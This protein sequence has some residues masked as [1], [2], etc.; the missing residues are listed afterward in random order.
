MSE[1]VSHRQRWKVV[2][3]WATLAALLL[4]II[5]ERH[6]I[7]DT[8]NNLGNINAWA[9]L[10][11]I[12]I[13]A[14]NYHAQARLYQGL[15][16]V[17]GNKLSYKSL[18]RASL[19]L[20]FVNH[21]FPSGGVTGMS[22]FS[23]RLRKGQELIYLATP[24]GESDDHDS[25]RYNGEGI[26]VLDPA[27]N[28]SF[29]K[30]IPLQN[31]PA[32]MK[33]EEVS[34]MMISPATNYAYISTR[35]HLIALDLATDK[36]V[37]SKTYDPINTCCERG[38]VTPDGLTLDVGSNLQNYHRV[39][40]A[41]T[42]DLKGIIPTPASPNN[43]NMVMS[44]DGKTIIAAPNGVTVTV[45]SMETMKPTKTITFSDHVRP[46]VINWDAS[47]I[48]ANLNN[49]LGF[50][51]ADVKSGKVIKRVEVPG[52]MWKAK[53]ADPNQ[54][55]FGH[56]APMHA[57]GLTPDESELW[58]G[59]AIN[60]QLLVFDNEGNDNWKL[61]MSK[62]LK[63]DHS[64]DWI[65]MGLDGKRAYLS[66]GD[67]VDV[68]THKVVGKLKDEWG[69]LIHSEKVLDVQFDDKG[70]VIRVVDQF[71]NGQPAA[72]KKRTAAN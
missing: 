7:F 55:F 48:Y 69:H 49:L 68:K 22:Y 36:I 2:L 14:L 61:N 37:W 16:S 39:I 72:V 25:T 24:G 70:H 8:A 34:A 32:S 10:F 3:N 66:S 63:L 29:V 5:A 50:E 56:G 21:V 27:T 67:V 17:V 31:L 4:V 6:Q 46:L 35:G 64:A 44:P 57:I 52:E 45:A 54:V 13:E 12:P 51:I 53:W 15:F 40:D 33:P 11:I 18:Y 23:L 30:R 65:T 71:A 38:A 26:I 62:A 1:T 47:R 20:N 19:E 28:Y 60:T 42:G 58:I 59:D 43:H 41:K 9:I